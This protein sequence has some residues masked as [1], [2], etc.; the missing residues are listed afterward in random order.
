MP[1]TS[2][3]TTELAENADPQ[4]AARPP[5]QIKLVGGLDI[6]P[7]HPSAPQDW[8]FTPEPAVACL[9]IVSLPDLSTLYEDQIIVQ[10]DVPY[11]PSYL[12]FR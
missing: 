6:T 3:P 7:M 5:K 8:P 2:Q 1:T 4:P 11:V 10:L 9:V 12:G